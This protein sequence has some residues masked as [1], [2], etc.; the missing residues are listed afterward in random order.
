MI[1]VTIR[2][3]AGFGD[4]FFCQK[5]AVRLM[6][7]GH[8]V[9]WP[10]IPEYQY[11]EEYITNGIIWEEPSCP[12]FEL[13]LG[14]S[15][16]YIT[17]TKG[18]TLY[19]NIM[20]AKYEYANQSFPIGDYKDWNKYFELN[21]FLDRE[22]ALEEFVLKGIP[23]KFCLVNKHFA[24]EYLR[25]NH[26]IKSDLPEVELIKYIGHN[27]FSWCGVIE[28][29]TEIRIP[30]S[31]YPYIVEILNTT[32]NLYLYSRNKENSLRT[33]KVWTKGWKFI[34]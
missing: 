13:N 12:T 20:Y 3:P 9:Y 1:P 18:K 10:V 5:I 31:S 11:I 32:D 25:I 29:A 6:E 7:M 24:T 8:I 22:K 33:K 30:D 17:W 19:D 23:D 34:E 14:H 26:V 16:N 27:L 21:R 2:Q 28:K 4:I 15:T